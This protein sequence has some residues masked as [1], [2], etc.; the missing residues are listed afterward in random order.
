MSASGVTV[1]RMDTGA[2]LYAAELEV[3]ALRE[4]A[5][6]ILQAEAGA[7]RRAAHELIEHLVAAEADPLCEDSPVLV[8][9]RAGALALMSRIE[10]ESG[11]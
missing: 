4:T 11:G 6:R 9:A 1:S 5:R 8:L 2:I 3:P 10:L 7:V